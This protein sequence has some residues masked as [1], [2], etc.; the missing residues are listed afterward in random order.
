MDKAMCGTC[1]KP[2]SKWREHASAPVVWRHGHRTLAPDGHAPQPMPPDD[3]MVMVCDFCSV[4]RPVWLYRTA[5]PTG[6]VKVEVEPKG[7]EEVMQFAREWGQ[8]VQPGQ[9]T[10]GTEHIYD[11]NWAACEGCAPFIDRRDIN[12]LISHVKATVS[13]AGHRPQTRDWL[14]SQ[15]REFFATVLPGRMAI[16]G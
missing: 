15:W 14:A 10:S 6:A 5:V 3:S 12:R 7:R 1:H 11:E 2:L 4:H 9:V 16:G 8:V 13:A